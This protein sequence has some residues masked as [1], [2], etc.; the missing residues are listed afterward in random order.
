MVEKIDEISYSLLKKS[1]D[2]SSERGRVIANNI[3]NVNTK[4]FKASR[5]VFEDK[6]NDA[7]EN[8]SIDLAT[9][10]EKHIKKGNSLSNLN[11]DVVKDK[12]TSMRTDGNNVDIDNE[13][14]NLAT[15][16]I[17]YNALINQANS[18]ISM[19]RLVIK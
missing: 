15:N 11:Y 19:R 17:L 3:A 16:T 8:R 12:S 2:A 13:M 1:L 18:R 10:N 6:L 4:G 5:V 9:T 7:L 14:V